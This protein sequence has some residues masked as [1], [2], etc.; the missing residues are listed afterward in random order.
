MN[1]IV[2][3]TYHET[4][5]LVSALFV[6]YNNREYYNLLGEENEFSDYSVEL[7]RQI[8]ALIPIKDQY[9]KYFQSCDSLDHCLAN[10]LLFSFMRIEEAERLDYKE[11]LLQR[12]HSYNLNEFPYFTDLSG[13]G[14]GFD[15]SKPY[16]PFVKSIRNLSIDEAYKMEICYSFYDFEQCINEL[17]E[18]LEETKA[19]LAPC[20]QAYQSLHEKVSKKLQQ[21]FTYD[22]LQQIFQFFYIPKNCHTIYLYPSLTSSGFNLYAKDHQDEANISYCLFAGI[23]FLKSASIESFFAPSKERIQEFLR[24]ISDPSKMEILLFVKDKAYYGGEIAK[25]LNLS[26]ST[27]SYHINSMVMLGLINVSKESNRI[28][29]QLNKKNLDSFFKQMQQL[30]LQDS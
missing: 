3:N 18:L 13:D 14:I 7:Y 5:E 2:S 12:F 10:I 27:I 4:K 26:T 24:L 28:Y 11:T 20:Y 1:I 16:R 21:Q 29:Y 17:W 19:L 22:H 8:H 15:F 23:S 9:K 25:H 6:R 30:F